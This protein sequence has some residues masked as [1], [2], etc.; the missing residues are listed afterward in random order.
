[1][2]TIMKG[3]AG[4][5]LAVMVCA[6]L[7]TSCYDDEALWESVGNLENSLNELKAQLD[8]QAEAMASLLSGGAT[9][10]SCVKQSDGSYL[11][12]LSDET[13]FKVLAPG[14]N[15]SS[16]MSYV[17]VGGEKYWALYS[18]TGELV[19]VTDANGN[20]IPVSTQVNVETKDGKYIIV[21]NGQSYETGVDAGEVVQVFQSCTPHADASGNVYAMTFT[22]GE[23]LEVTVSVDGYKGVLFR[24]ENANSSPLV[25]DYYVPYGTKQ[26]FLL[27]MEG[28]IEYAALAPS[29]W[30]AVERV[31]KQSGNVYLD[32]T[33]PS[34]ALVESGLAFSDGVLKVVSIIE[35]GDATITKLELSAE[36][37]KTLNVSSTRFAAEPYNG[38]VK[39]VY[40][41]MEQDGYDEAA[42]LAEVEKIITTS[43]DLPAGYG[44]A[45]SSVNLPIA[46]VLGSA[47]NPEKRYF[48]FVIPALYDVYL[49]SVYYI[50]P[51][52]L[53]TFDV[54]AIIATM[55]EPVASLI[56]AEISVEII[57][58]DK[59]WAGTALKSDD[60]FAEIIYSIV[61]GIA[62]PYTEGL[63]YNGPASAYPVASANADVD[64]APGTTYV[65]WCVPFDPDKTTYTEEDI[66]YREFTT[67][68]LTSGGT[69]SLVAGEATV[70]AGSISIPLSSEGAKMIYY[71]FLT[72]DEGKRLGSTT[73]MDE[74]KF[75]LLIK[76]EN[77]TLVKAD[78]T[79]AYVEGLVPESTMWLYAVAVGADGKYGTVNC[80]SATLEKVKFNALTVAYDS[81]D[82]GADKIEYQVS[83]TG[84]TATDY[85]YWIGTTVDPLW[86]KCGKDRKVLEK[87]MAVYP[88]DDAIARVMRA[89]GPVSEDGKI[90]ITGLRM[91]EEYIMMI[92]AK[93]E[94]GA[95]S[96]GA[97]KL[98][99]TLA[100][101][102][103]V[104]VTTGSDKWN[105]EKANIKIDWIKEGFQAAAS[106]AM[107]ARYAFNFSCPQ[108]YTAFILCASETYFDDAGFT[109]MSQIMIEIENYC[110]RKYDDGRTPFINGEYALEPDYY[111]EG[112]LRG[113][114]M[115][116]VVDFYVHGLPTMG[117]ATYFAPDSHGDG[118]CIYW[119]N[120]HDANYQRALDM[121]AS[122]KTLAKY[123]ARAA[124]F[125]LKG[126]EA[127][128]WA[129]ALLE[130]YLP[131]YENAEPL[132]YF[133]NGEPL[134]M[135]NP[136]A[137]GIDDKGAVPDRVIV[138]LKDREGKY[139]EPMYFEV[140]NYFE[141][142]E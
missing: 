81:W 95:Y 126:Q 101:D 106:Q 16:L 44:V 137:M 48:L 94:T 125:G 47:L 121:I 58:T 112:E 91:E 39:Y 36:P 41:L 86:V 111:K 31:D 62:D 103:G 49:E 63:V 66:V 96:K 105:E 138:M 10:K 9:I 122:Y 4:A 33:A 8:S 68:P 128:D 50:D 69:L 40:G 116:N 80:Q 100:A 38:V 72:E 53:K 24:I 74:N 79:V 26:T 11:I 134:Y 113:G 87:Y 20:N 35:G 83:V 117:F 141:T 107:M 75:N 70:T 12:I 15:T 110:S 118:N 6:P 130:A 52:M 127:S 136:Y 82:V 30:K 64:F 119:E 88:E 131:Y 25:S 27:D 7:L 140:P 71:A 37:F 84:G 139:F 57:G 13:K 123:E 76:S 45:E 135:M 42:I 108:D 90:T 2:K 142:E 124:A 59:M 104:V 43:A 115:M 65:T 89:N 19:P 23:G 97:Y 61:N 132:I 21:I 133:N 34:K 73:G 51:S 78:E 29:G 129:K 120:G 18:S 46:S 5:L 114:Q 93:D 102:L 32:I 98:L 109:K 85:I 14:A 17:V 28:V 22:F 99:T 92:L 3:I 56:D 54:G 60:L 55:S 67:S 77:C 1:M